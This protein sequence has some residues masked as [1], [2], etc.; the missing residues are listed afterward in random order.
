MVY[1]LLLILYVFYTIDMML[2]TKQFQVIFLFE[3]KMG[4]KAAEA[5]CNVNNVFGPGTAT[6]HIVQWLFKKFCRASLV[7]L[8]K[9]P[10]ANVGDTGSIS[11]P[12]RC[13][14]LQSS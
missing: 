4:R 6:E 12:G 8:V 11:S 5:T 13:H 7:T 10:P 1:Y 9:N 3:F 2:D 14:V